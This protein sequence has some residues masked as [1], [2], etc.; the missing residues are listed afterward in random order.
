MIFTINQKENHETEKGECSLSILYP[1][2]L[3]QTTK[4]LNAA[5]TVRNVSIVKRCFNIETLE[6]DYQCEML[7]HHWPTTAGVEMKRL[8]LLDT[9]LENN[10]SAEMS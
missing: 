1:E 2:A 7:L 5:S 3:F 9:M 4:L 8:Y 6:K 10:D